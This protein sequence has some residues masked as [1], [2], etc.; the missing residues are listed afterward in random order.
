M[1]DEFDL[2]GPNASLNE[3][4][5]TKYFI[6]VEKCDKHAARTKIEERKIVGKEPGEVSVETTYTPYIVAK[7]SYRIVY[8]RRNRYAM[9][10]PPGVAT[11]K[12]LDRVFTTN[13]II[14]N[15]IKVDAAEKIT[16]EQE[17]STELNHKGERIKFKDIPPHNEVNA[18]FYEEHQAQIER[19][20]I[21]MGDILEKFRDQ[22]VHRPKDVTR[23]IE[24]TF[25]AEIQIILRTYYWGIFKEDNKEKRMRID[26]VTGKVE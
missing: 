25:I 22:L 3:K 17:D 20:K 11:V 6:C 14:R 8:L 2:T 23:S 12:V 21:N 7:A 1:V 16:V 19:P 15:E 24:E 13:E 4:I 9:A 5:T 18:S 26:S 10:I